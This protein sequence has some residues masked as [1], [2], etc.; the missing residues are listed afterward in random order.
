MTVYFFVCSLVGLVLSLSHL[1]SL[2]GNAAAAGH[3]NFFD[4]SYTMVLQKRI[5]DV[6][7]SVGLDFVA[8]PYGIGGTTSAPE[9]AGC[10]KEIF[11]MDVDMVRLLKERCAKDTHTHTHKQIRRH[12]HLF[13]SL[14]WSCV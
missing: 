5:W 14:R 12:S 13:L 4:Q 3:G 8:R 11:G 9:I 2:S 6:F 7:H 1:S 10:A